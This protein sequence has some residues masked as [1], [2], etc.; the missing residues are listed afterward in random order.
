VR[1][2]LTESIR[3][4]DAGEVGVF[5]PALERLADAS[6]LLGVV[7]EL[8]PGAKVGALARS[9]ARSV[10]WF[11]LTNGSNPAATAPPQQDSPSQAILSSL[12]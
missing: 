4:A 1:R 2:Q 3:V 8:S 5:L 9:C 7:G 11:Y 12:R 10:A 6:V